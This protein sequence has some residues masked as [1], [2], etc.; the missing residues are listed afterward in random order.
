[1]IV[2]RTFVLAAA[3]LLFAACNSETADAKE[4]A[5][6]KELRFSVIP[7]FNK[8]QLADA[9]AK[10]AEVLTKE[11][12]IPVIYKPSNDYTMAVNGLVSN[13]LDFVWLG[14]KTTCDAIDAGE[15]KVHVLATR[16]IDLAFKSYFI[17]N[18]AAIESGKIGK[19]ENL[20]A[21]KGKAGDVSFTFGDQNSTSGHLMPRHFLT[22]A[23]I[24][25]EKDFKGKAGYQASGGHAATLQAVANGT[26]DLGAL[27]FAYYDKASAEDNATAPIVYVTPDYVDY[28]WVVHDRLGADTIN[29]LRSAFTGL[30]AHDE[31]ENAILTAWSGGKFLPAKDEQWNSIRQ[32][33]DSLPKGF[34]K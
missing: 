31:T 12:G 16:D 10:V 26:V 33:R 2:F 15:G 11:L 1:M 13:Q 24:D 5:S 6:P 4:S 25:P 8:G 20:S 23:G 19:L 34:L 22:Q 18:Q 3:S 28:A 27:N 21:L 29:K 32:V 14:G 17:A 30:D 9:C 7:D